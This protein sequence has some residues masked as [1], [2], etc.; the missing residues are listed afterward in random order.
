MLTLERAHGARV[1]AELRSRFPQLPEP[2]VLPW[3]ELP[4]LGL[5]RETPWLY[6]PI[7]RDPLA[8]SYGRT[9]VP[10]REIRRLRKLAA[11]EVPFQR[12]AIAHELD[13]DGAVRDLLPE[14]RNGPR[15]CTD[16]VASAVV[17]PQPVHPAVRGT[18]RLLDAIVGQ[19][20]GKA[21]AG[22][23]ATALDPIVLGAV[24][25]PETTHGQLALFYPLSAWRW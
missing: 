18:A 7:E 4:V 2:L 14:L 25:M 20:L 6:G 12:I 24:G 8:A 5:D 15:T 10:R 21:M 23:L 1:D 19:R 9:V 13:P 11:W 22:A 16:A 3:S 17:G